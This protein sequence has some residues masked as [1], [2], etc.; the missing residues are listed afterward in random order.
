MTNTKGDKVIVKKITEL[1]PYSFSPADLAFNANNPSEVELNSSLLASE[2]KIINNAFYK[3]V[4]PEQIDLQTKEIKQASLDK[5][6]GFIHLSLGSQVKNVVN[7]FFKNNEKLFL[8][9][10]NADEIQKIGGEI[11]LESN[12]T[13][14]T[15]YPH[16]YKLEKIPSNSI[17]NIIECKI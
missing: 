10:I 9:E 11:K 7:K 3:I 13:G 8:V 14:G 17:N 2:M 12:H 5:E 16:L 1:V 6:S 15:Q 4:T